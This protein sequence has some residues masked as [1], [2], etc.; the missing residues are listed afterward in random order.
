MFYLKELVNNL[1]YSPK[2]FKL[3]YENLYETPLPSLP[4]TNNPREKQNLHEQSC[5]RKTDKKNM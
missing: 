3:G 2:G 5:K 4:R 1:K